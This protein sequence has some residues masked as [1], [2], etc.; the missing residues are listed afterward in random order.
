MTQPVPPIQSSRPKYKSMMAIILAILLHVVIAII[1][2]VTVF[3]H[4]SRSPSETSLLTD[5]STSASISQ[6]GQPLNA[7]TTSAINPTE[8]S[9]ISADNANNAVS[10]NARSAQSRQAATL[11]QRSSPTEN[12]DI[13]DDKR[14]TSDLKPM[15]NDTVASTDSASIT[16]QTPAEY[17]LKT[18][19]EYQELD[20]D[21]DKDNEQLSKLIG[22]IKNYNQSQI[23]QHQV[24]KAPYVPAPSPP[25]PSVQYDYPITPITPQP[26]IDNVPAKETSTAP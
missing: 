25:A 3:D 23:Q 15:A 6:N 7:I 14:A 17:Q 24:H 10:D 9:N 4:K 5:T 16:E 2:Y 26:T 11:S 19:K 20:K 13:S 12:N 1:I 21:I 18:T 8:T 22:E